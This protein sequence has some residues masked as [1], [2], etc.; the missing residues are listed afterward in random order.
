MQYGPPPC[1]VCGSPQVAK[2]SGKPGLWK[3]QCETCTA[4]RLTS[5]PLQSYIDVFAPVER[6]MRVRPQSRSQ[7]SDGA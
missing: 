3:V 7:E 2:H 5:N 6:Q 1:C 4:E